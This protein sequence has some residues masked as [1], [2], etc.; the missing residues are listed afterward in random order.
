MR[1]FG[2]APGVSEDAI[3]PELKTEHRVLSQ[4]KKLE[5][6]KTEVDRKKCFPKVPSCRLFS[7]KG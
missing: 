7:K 5:E 2:P 6:I 1:R 4:N 3:L